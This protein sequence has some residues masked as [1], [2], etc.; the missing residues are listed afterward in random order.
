MKKAQLGSLATLAIL[1]GVAIIGL[2]VISDVISSLQED[3]QTTST[4]T[5]ANQTNTQPTAPDRWILLAAA[6]SNPYYAASDSGCI[7]I[8][9]VYNSSKNGTSG[10][11]SSAH[12]KVLNG[13]TYRPIINFTNNASCTCQ[14]F[15][16]C[17]ISY[18]Y[19]ANDYP[20]AFNIS[21]KGMLGAINLSQRFPVIGTVLG[22]SIIIGILLVY[23]VKGK[24]ES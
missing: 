24:G 21:G 22:A 16:G 6:N 4:V 14:S 11:C 2:S 9:A 17:N 3:E 12:Y 7:S 8:S 13:S 20:A 18:T 10:I 15:A 19:C 5:V 23:F 1:F